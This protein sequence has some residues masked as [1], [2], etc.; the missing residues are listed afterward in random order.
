MPQGQ[1]GD[2]GLDQA[3]EPHAAHGRFHNAIEVRGRKQEG[4]GWIAS[5]FGLHAANCL[6]ESFCLAIHIK[7]IFN[8]FVMGACGGRGDVWRRE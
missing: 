3:I 6:A 4:Q 1:H 5:S 8:D 7:R 2:V